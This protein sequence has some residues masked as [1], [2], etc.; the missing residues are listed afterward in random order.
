MFRK[1]EDFE[2]AWKY[3]SEQTVKLFNELTDDSL[4]QK[5]SEEGRTLGFLAWHLAVTLEE[6]P[7]LV[8]LTIDAPNPET[9]CPTVAK[10]IVSA[11]KKARIL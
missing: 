8:G 1:I 3:E 2:R 9:E 4:N 11:F 7:K 10:E 6:M 5:V